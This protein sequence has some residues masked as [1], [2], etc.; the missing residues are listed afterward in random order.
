[1]KSIYTLLACMLVTSLS[2]YAQ[3]QGVGIGASNPHASAILEL[4]ATNQGFLLPRIN[5]TSINDNTT[6]ASPATGLMVY[7]TNAAITGG[8]G[9][10][11][12]FWNGSQWSQAVG[13]AGPA[14]PAGPQGPEGPLVSGTS[15]QTLRHNGTSWIANSNLFN[16]GSNV[17]IGSTNP[18]ARLEIN[19]AN[20]SGWSGNLKAARIL[21]PDNGFNLDLNTYVI[22]GGNVGYQFSPNGNTGMVIS[23]PG[24]VGIGTT[25]PL[26]T[27]DVGG[28][29]AMK[30]PVGT[31]AQ[32]PG[33]AATGMMRY[34]TSYNKPEY[35]DGANWRTFEVR[36]NAIGTG[37]NTTQD[38]GGYRIHTFTTSGTFTTTYAG[39]VEVLAVAGGGG[40]AGSPWGGGGGGGGGVIHH[41]GFFVNEGP[42]TVTVGAGGAA[43]SAGGDSFF[44]PMQAFGGGAACSSCGPGGSGGGTSH[45]NPGGNNNPSTQTSNNG[46]TGYGNYGGH[47]V[48]TS[49]YWMGSGGGAGAP[50][51]YAG[52]GGAGRIFDIS[53]TA[54][55]YAGGGGQVNNN[56]N[57]TGGGAGGG[58]SGC[59]GCNGGVGAANTGGGG[60]GSRGGAG[61][62]GGSGIVIVRYPIPN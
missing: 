48:Y 33:T 61:G 26:A 7:N 53:G 16:T 12:Y 23:T 30:M 56:G 43:S 39:T 15:G 27:L 52:A 22:A 44:G 6:I 57:V 49:P 5:L 10:G 20:G 31:T 41:T 36:R 19:L 55:Y 50:G 37:G 45:S 42:V 14:G 25:N 4:R 60:G 1:M 34:N 47:S 28:T 29:G 18:T 2:L 62:A 9:I 21:A 40:G 3:P 8:N 54:T 13:A 38:I 51:A 58:G 32:R 24:N 59:N 35:F 17:G 11:F 46:G